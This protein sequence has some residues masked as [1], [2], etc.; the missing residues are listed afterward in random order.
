MKFQVN[1]ENA[2][3]NRGNL[4]RLKQFLERA[5]RGEKLNIGFIGGSITMG[6]AATT[7]QKAYAWLIY[8]W[9]QKNFRS[10]NFHILMQALAQRLL[11]LRQHEQK[12]ICFPIN[13]T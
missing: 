7:P 3:A 5:K 4:Y 1:C 8:E 11:S 9:F 2:I 12:A 6:C 10:Q 13:R